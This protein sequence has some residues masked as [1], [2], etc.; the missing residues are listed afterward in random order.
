MN[1]TEVLRHEVRDEVE[2]R[3]HGNERK[4]ANVSVFPYLDLPLR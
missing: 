4:D 2:V 1:G 3:S